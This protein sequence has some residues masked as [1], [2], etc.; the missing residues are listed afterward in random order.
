M[1]KTRKLLAL[2]MVLAIMLSMLILP[3]SAAEIEEEVV[4]PYYVAAICKYCGGSAKRVTVSEDSETV[5][6]STSKCDVIPLDHYHEVTT[7]VY[8]VDCSD[9][10]AYYYLATVES[11]YCPFKTDY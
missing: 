4:S 6:V 1:K 8:Y 3:A 7:Y 11:H 9:C 5:K 2:L 10:G